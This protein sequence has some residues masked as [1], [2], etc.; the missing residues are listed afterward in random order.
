MDSS[1]LALA[2][3][4]AEKKIRLALEDA[5]A[6]PPPNADRP[7]P[8]SAAAAI[9]YDVTE[10]GYLAY[11][12]AQTARD[13]LA[14][15][16]H[17]LWI[18]YPGLQGLNSATASVPSCNAVEGTTA[19]PTTDAGVSPENA[20]QRPK[21]VADIRQYLH[22]QLWHAQSEIGVAID[23]VNLLLASVK[24]ADSGNG[25]VTAANDPLSLITA[26][27]NAGTTTIT[28]TGATNATAATSLASTASVAAAGG[29]NNPAT[30]PPLPLPANSISYTYTNQPKPDL[31]T[32]IHQVKLALGAKRKHL[33]TASQILSLHARK[34]ETVIA[35][36]QQFWIQALALRQKHWLLQARHQRT[37][38]G[39]SGNTS[40][41]HRP[42]GSLDRSTFY[43]VYGYEAAGTVFRERGLADLLRSH[44]ATSAS[45]IA[46]S[47]ESLADDGHESKHPPT[48]GADT[49]A[50]QLRLPRKQQLALE[51]TLVDRRT[52]KRL[53]K[54]R[55]WTI[56][57]SPSSSTL[58]IMEPTRSTP[59]NTPTALHTQL[60]AAQ[61]GLFESE[62]FTHVLREAKSFGLNDGLSEA[63]QIVRIPLSFVGQ[64]LLN[65]SVLASTVAR[66]GDLD[67]TIQM[68]EQKP[69]ISEVSALE[70]SWAR[71]AG[72]HGLVTHPDF[73]KLM[74]E[75]AF[76]RQLK[77]AKTRQAD[78]Q[79][80][81]FRSDLRFG[82]VNLATPPS[83]LL[84]PPL[85]ASIDY[86]ATAHNLFD[87]LRAAQ[88][89]WRG[90]G[91]PVTATWSTFAAKSKGSTMAAP[92]LDSAGRD[93]K[94]ALYGQWSQ[95][96]RQLFEASKRG[97]RSGPG[98]SVTGVNSMAPSAVP[99]SGAQ[100][101]SL[102]V[103]G[104]G[105]TQSLAL[106]TA[107]IPWMIVAQQC[108]AHVAQ[109]C[110][111]TLTI[112]Q[113]QSFRIRVRRGDTL[114]VSAHQNGGNSSA[115]GAPV[116]LGGIGELA[117]WFQY[118]FAALLTKFSCRALLSLS[119][120]A[121]L[122]GSG[123]NGT[124]LV[125]VAP[126]LSSR[127]TLT[128][129]FTSVETGATHGRWELWCE[130]VLPLSSQIQTA[131]ASVHAY[132]HSMSTTEMVGSGAPAAPPPLAD[133]TAVPFRLSSGQLV[134]S[135][136]WSDWLLG[137]TQRFIL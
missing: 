42:D 124:G 45:S 79:R 73:M 39:G 119:G 38:G 100:L 115:D 35:S 80:L 101:A 116:A 127:L 103:G 123:H 34:L 12:P 67:L 31:V 59:N 46:A 133:V 102:L 135:V 25:P 57:S 75:L 81:E 129:N 105:G 110:M 111:V 19:T 55:L 94:H 84:L 9:P 89:L 53:A 49:S 14:E 95:L 121:G 40:G 97:S 71:D 74:L 125:T 23:V 91:I 26:G 5:T 20:T 104:G 28:N 64:Q 16:V 136:Q 90:L 130:G 112:G 120:W 85:L 66:T 48:T 78:K 76:C 113:S 82:R 114:E 1:S 61:Y 30:G 117:E 77:F 13:R 7:N 37:A 126:N 56:R 32:Q 52:H 106:R 93:N 6:L 99:A 68:V 63:Q 33:H 65:S 107:I 134:P 87:L 21:S 98:S 54:S 122:N 51:L 29:P 109:I 58:P 47:G 22:E 4:P 8:A 131:A 88:D 118:Q 62:L 2:G 69:S 27:S 50:L 3:P 44:N 36:E 92:N 60:L 41:A 72:G 70:H 128:L 137:L 10:D 17:Q 24:P 83:Y 11:K 132:L 86:A 15:R 43:V 108:P 96:Q 18:Q